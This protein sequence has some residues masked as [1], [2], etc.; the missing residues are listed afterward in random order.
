[1]KK[2]ILLII[3]IFL[4]FSLLACRENIEEGDII[5]DTGRSTK[6]NEKEVKAAID[7]VKNEFDFEGCT[8][9]KLWYDEEESDYATS[10]YLGTG[11]GSINKVEPENVIVVLS[12]FD[13]D[14]AGGDGAFEPNS[15]YADWQFILIRDDKKDDWKIDSWG[16]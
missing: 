13:V 1:M 15:T 9:K 3:V 2:A 4:V 14:S 6:F 8:L 5:I 10:A 11:R 7:T 16:Y 12:E